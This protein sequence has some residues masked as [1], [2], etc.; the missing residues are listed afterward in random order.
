V[1]ASLTL[2][3]RPGCHLCHELRARVERLIHGTA[4]ALVERNIED[5]ETLLRRYAL[6]IPVLL[7]GERE[8]ARHGVSQA[9]LRARLEE[10]KD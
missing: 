6:S 3:S 10:L 9:D 7:A 8:I 5:D 1:A 2:L 4:L